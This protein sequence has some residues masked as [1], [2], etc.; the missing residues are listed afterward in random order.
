MA[1]ADPVAG[2]MLSCT[3]ADHSARVLKNDLYNAFLAWCNYYT[4]EKMSMRA[5]NKR[6]ADLRVNLGFFEAVNSQVT[7]NNV[8]RVGNVIIGRSLKTHI[9]SATGVIVRLNSIV[10]IQGDWE[11]KNT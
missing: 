11:A 4:V 8:T 2:F 1:Y 7:V 9:K 3:T 6:L 5:F 10:G